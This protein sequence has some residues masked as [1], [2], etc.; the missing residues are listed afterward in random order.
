MGVA[1]FADGACGRAPAH[2]N[3]QF[4]CHSVRLSA[5]T[6]FVHRAPSLKSGFLNKIILSGSIP[7]S[8]CPMSQ[9]GTF[10]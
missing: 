8:R 6:S 5:Q 4:R 3:E 7:S 1:L 9:C 10:I 2:S